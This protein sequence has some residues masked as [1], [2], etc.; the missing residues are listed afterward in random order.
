[1]SEVDVPPFNAEDNML[2]VDG[3]HFKDEGE[4]EVY[5]GAGTCYAGDGVTFL[6]LFD[7]DEY[8]ECRKENLFYPFASKE[9]WEVADF[10]L[11]SPLSMAAINQFLE[12]PMIHRLKLDQAGSV[13]PF[14]RSI[15]QKV[16]SDCFGGIPW[17]LNFVPHRIYMTLARLLHVYSEWLTGDTAWEIQDQ[18]PRGATV[19]GTVLSSDKMNITNMTGARVTH[20]LL[21]GLANIHMNTCTKLS[22]RAFLLTALLP[23]PQYL[24][25]KPRMWGMLEDRL[26]HECL[27][28]VLKPLMKATKIGIMMS[29]PVGN[30]CHCFTPLVAYIV[31]TPE[32][33]WPLANPSVFLTPEPLHH[34]HKEFYDYDVQWCLTVVE[35]QE[36][37][38]R[39][40][41][42]QPTT[43]YRHFCGGILKLKQVMGRVHR[44]LQCYLVGLIAGAAPCQ[45]VI[46][47]RALMD[48]RYM[49]QSPS[50]DENLLVRIDRSLSIFHENKDVI[51]SLGAQMGMKKPIDNWFIPK[52]EL[53][54]SITASSCKVGALIQWSTDTTEHAH[55]S[56]IKD[57][58]Q[59]TNNN[60]Y[61]PQ[62]CRHL[63]CQEKLRH[64]TI[65]TTLK[66]TCADS[67]LEEFFED[68]VDEE[69]EE[70]DGDCDEPT[71]PRT[72]LL[73]ELNQM[74]ITTN[75]FSKAKKLVATRCNN[76]SHPPRTFIAAATTIH[77]NFDPT[78]T[79][80]K[81]D[82]VANDFNI[83]DLRQVLSDFLQRDVRNREAGHGLG[84]PRR[85]LIDCPSVLP[86]EHIQIWH[87]V[88]LQQVSF[89]DASVV[90]PAQ[91]VHASP[92]SPASGWPKGRWDAVLVNIDQAY[93]LPKSGLM[94]ELVYVDTNL[95]YC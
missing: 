77:L 46:A 26:M 39:I 38:F 94:G 60:D 33:C 11:C 19:L 55:I 95:A 56:E 92:P 25:S 47:I 29:D 24:H 36:L 91:T 2:N 9:E 74:H 28:I 93:D 65:A 6:D 64:F 78:H 40:S 23:I 3:A 32:A 70:D 31:D 10:L 15:P 72:A 61:D 37:D 67:N 53:M 75:Y 21:L 14:L 43:G 18:L 48:V 69:D 22:S 50:P 63:D 44:D 41:I 80:L 49:A 5:E 71:D 73:A 35:T 84:V 30:V 7:G 87:T 88:H 86:F 42:L 17:N 1:M 16:L 8:A 59:H 20:P 66:S 54:Q 45:F 34:W 68:E 27:S 13:E 52:L 89:Y 62:I 83:P 90:L 81:I 58:V 79:G 85:Q 57:P 51:I 82:E 12:L 4:V 76:I